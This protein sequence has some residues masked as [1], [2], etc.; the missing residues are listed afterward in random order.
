MPDLQAQHLWRVAKRP[1]LRDVSGTQQEKPGLF[2]NSALPPRRSAAYQRAALARRKA[3][4]VPPAAARLAS[5]VQRVFLR[6][7]PIL[8]RR[9][10]AAA[11]RH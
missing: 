9:S 4:P 2:P 5:P 6:R 1:S 8:S 7:A 10:P 3:V 11:S